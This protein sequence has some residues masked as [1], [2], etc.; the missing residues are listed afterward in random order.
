MAFNEEFDARYEHSLVEASKSP[1]DAYF[2]DKAERRAAHSSDDETEEGTSPATGVL[3][4]D[5]LRRDRGHH[6]NYFRP[7]RERNHNEVEITFY[8][9][10]ERLDEMMQYRHVFGDTDFTR[11]LS[12]FLTAGC[13]WMNEH[14]A[15]VGAAQAMATE[16]KLLEQQRDAL[17]ETIARLALPPKRNVWR[18][19]FGR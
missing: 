5:A 8:C 3:S 15:E 9:A 1:A 7:Q 19:L 17:R 2:R 10:R 12:R 16:V 11:S 4:M 6:R 18:R 14:Q 13:H